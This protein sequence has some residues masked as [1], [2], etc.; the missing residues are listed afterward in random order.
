MSISGREAKGA[1]GRG[2]FSSF[3]RDQTA[4]SPSFF[5]FFCYGF[6]R[7]WNRLCT[8]LGLGRRMTGRWDDEFSTLSLLMARTALEWDWIG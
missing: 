7:V 1:R 8:L 6:L 2:V 4:L 5:L 3:S